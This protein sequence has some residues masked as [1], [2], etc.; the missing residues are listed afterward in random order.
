MSE[1]QRAYHGDDDEFLDQFV[2]EVINRTIDQLRSIIRGHDFDARRKTAL[3]LGE[4]VLNGPN[5]GP[6]ILSGA[7]HN[8]PAGDLSFTIELRHAAPHFRT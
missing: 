2:R 5:G 4:L 1:E 7:H 6:R 8:H 3:Q